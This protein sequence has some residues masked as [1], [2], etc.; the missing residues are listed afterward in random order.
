VYHLELREFPHNSHAYN[1]EPA[2]LEATILDPWVRGEIFEFGERQWIPQRTKLTILE[3]ERLPLHALSMGRGWNAA[4]RKGKDVTEEL[5]ETARAKLPHAA[6]DA[7]NE[8]A[9]ARDILARCA[10]GPLSLAAVWDRAEIAAPDASSGEWLVLA[11][12][13][14]LRLISGGQIVLCRGEAA[15][16]PTIATDEIEPVL[17]TRE[18]WSSDSANALFVH[19]A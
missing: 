16:A 10:D 19:A 8:Q 12:S 18:A 3:G 4:R 15:T 1:V 9:V 2:R 13:A 7:D 11:Q 14:L 5:L 6:L 17:R